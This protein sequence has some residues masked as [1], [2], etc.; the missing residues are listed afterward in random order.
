MWVFWERSFSDVFL[1]IGITR[2]KR[3][4]WRKSPPS[5][6]PSVPLL[7]TYSW[8]GEA[9]VSWTELY[10]DDWLQVIIYHRFTA[11]RWRI[12]VGIKVPEMEGE[13]FFQR[14]VRLEAGSHEAPSYRN[15]HMTQ[16]LIWDKLFKCIFQPCR[17]PT[18]MVLRRSG[19][20]SSELGIEINETFQGCMHI[21]NRM[22]CC[23]M[24]YWS[25]KSFNCD[26]RLLLHSTC[27]SIRSSCPLSGCGVWND[28]TSKWGK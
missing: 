21:S 14:V 1:K 9:D 13:A 7:S 4:Q 11:S 8:A 18:C 15:S 2:G 3:L 17:V 28:N 12:M 25:R 20:L 22:H 19:F 26:H 24:Y 5:P 23:V 16:G 27:F 10:D 6:P